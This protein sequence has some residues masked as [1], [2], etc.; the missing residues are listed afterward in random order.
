MCVSPCVCVVLHWYVYHY[1]SDTALQSHSPPTLTIGNSGSF[2]LPS[3]FSLAECYINGI[4]PPV[5]FR[6][7][8]FTLSIMPLR[9]IQ[10]CSFCFFNHWVVFYW[11]SQESGQRICLPM[12]K[13]RVRSLG[14]EDPLEKEMETHSSML[15]W[16][17][18]W[19]EEPDRLQPMGSQKSQTWLSD[20]TTTEFYCLGRAA[21]PLDHEWTC[22][23][24]QIS[25]CQ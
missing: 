16:K 2:P 3:N 17:M 6:D 14:W 8:L 15:A 10:V 9:S 18:P 7:W 24:T 13:T 19:I 5:T 12:W 22:W 21:Q 23:P 11:A 1:C 25:S 4:I 20:W